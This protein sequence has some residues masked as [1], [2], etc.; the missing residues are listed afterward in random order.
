V[1]ASQPTYL[2]QLV[3]LGFSSKRKMLRNNLKGSV[4]RDQLLA[5]MADLGIA[6]TARAEDMSVEQWVALSNRLGRRDTIL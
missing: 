1:A 3:R 5:A 2:D 6:A 4:D